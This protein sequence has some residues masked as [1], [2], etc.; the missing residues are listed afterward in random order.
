MQETSNSIANALELRLS[1]SNPSIYLS[2]SP[3]GPIG[4]AMYRM[5][6]VQTFRPDRLMTAAHHFVDA[7][8]GSTFMQAGSKELNLADVV[9]NEVSEETVGMG[10]IDCSGQDCGNSIALALGV[11][12]VL[13]WATDIKS[14]QMHQ[15]FY[16]NEIV[17]KFKCYGMLYTINVFS[18]FWN[19]YCVYFHVHVKV[20]QNRKV[21]SP[22]ASSTC[23]PDCFL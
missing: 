5:L 18:E 20:V 2:L 23:V 21:L 11:P 1:C 14:Y 16:S 9:E 8:L 4:Q 19:F 12:A 15:I 3:T 6:M 22:L 10:H 17:S 13:R 7:A